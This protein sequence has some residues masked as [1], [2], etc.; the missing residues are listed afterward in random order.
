M[1]GPPSVLYL[2]YYINIGLMSEPQLRISPR[3]YP[4]RDDDDTKYILNW[5]EA[6]GS[7]KY[8]WEFGEEKFR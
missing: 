3:I 7:L 6:Y 1:L 2:L 8:G 5:C 4:R